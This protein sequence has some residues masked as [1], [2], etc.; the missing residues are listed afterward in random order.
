MNVPK[1]RFPEFLGA[2]EWSVCSLEEMTLFVGNGLSLEQ[3]QVGVGYKVTRIETISDKK[4][5]LEKVGYVDTIL[6][7]SSYKLESGDILLSNINSLSHIGK[8]AYVDKDYDLYHGMNLLRI[9]INRQSHCSGF[10]FYQLSTE[11]IKKE[12][13][14]KANKAVNQ[15]SINQTEVKKTMMAVPKSLNEQQ[16]IANCLS[17]LDELVTAETQKLAALKDHKKGL[18]QQIFPQTGETTPRVRFPE[19]LGAGEWEEKALNKVCQINPSVDG[20]PSIF[21]YI[22]LESVEDGA[23]LQK[24]IIS[25]DSA[26]SRAQRLLKN[27]DVIFQMVRPYQKNNYF[28]DSEDKL[29][30]V[31]STGYAQLRAHESNKYLFH[32]LH[33]DRFI[34]RVL[35]KCTG[36]NYPAIN[37]SDLSNLTIEIPKP[38][39][40]QKIAN[41]LSSLDELITAQTRKID[42]LKTHKKG[43]MQGLFPLVKGA[44]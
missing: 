1:L 44:D 33:N 26:P 34:K 38:E 11:K 4:I 14:T 7:V 41:C 32:Y 20:L 9:S 30:Y 37:S 13:E 28:F 42:A 31:A 6:D 43:L 12:F 10:V 18:M 8:V 24:K 19:F 17:S 27:G 16:K 35:A 23:L 25:L 29:H 36:S 22:D 5:N 15:A 3:N 39:E 40:Q 21:V 2:G